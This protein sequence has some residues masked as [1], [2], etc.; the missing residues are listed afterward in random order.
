MGASVARRPR[1][2]P[3]LARGQDLTSELLALRYAAR[4]NSSAVLSLATTVNGL[5]TKP[6]RANATSLAIRRSYSAPCSPPNVRRKIGGAAGIRTRV[7]SSYYTRIYRHSLR[8]DVINISSFG[9]GLKR[10]FDT[11]LQPGSQFWSHF[12]AWPV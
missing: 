3:D 5:V 10:W 6:I 9:R 8:R 12:L 11:L 4:A 7:R 2:P 1:T